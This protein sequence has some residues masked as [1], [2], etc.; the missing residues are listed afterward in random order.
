MTPPIIA[1]LH[2]VAELYPLSSYLL[3][4]IVKAIRG[5]V[6]LCA[7]DRGHNLAEMGLSTTETCRGDEVTV[8]FE[9][10]KS[11]RGEIWERGEAMIDY[12]SIAQV[13]CFGLLDSFSLEEIAEKLSVDARTVRSW[14][15]NGELRAV[16]V[17]RNQQSKKPRLRIMEDDVTNFLTLRSVAATEKVTRRQRSKPCRQ[18]V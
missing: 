11:G 7:F 12:L 18:W 10:M 17:S 8:A 15:A 16:N 9:L 13:A 1:D 4:R 6:R 5:L 14:I 2:K 3:D